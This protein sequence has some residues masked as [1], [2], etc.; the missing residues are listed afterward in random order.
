MGTR[1]LASDDSPSEDLLV[2]AP[3]EEFEALPPISVIPCTPV[4][5]QDVLIEAGPRAIECAIDEE[6]IIP[7]VVEW[8]DCS[9]T[10]IGMKMIIVNTTSGSGQRVTVHK[11]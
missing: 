8:I 4:P 7:S 3:C 1:Q 5:D 10:G 2:A 6:V 9:G 11:Q